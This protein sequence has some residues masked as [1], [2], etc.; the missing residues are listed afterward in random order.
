MSSLAFDFL[1]WGA[2]KFLAGVGG[3]LFSEVLI[4]AGFGSEVEI[5]NR[6]DRIDQGLIKVNESL[7]EVQSQLVEICRKLDMM[8]EAMKFLAR[9]AQLMVAWSDISAA[10]G[11]SIAPDQLAEPALLQVG[12]SQQSLL[13]LVRN[14]QDGLYKPTQAAQFKKDVEEYWKVKQ[15][16]QRMRTMMTDSSLTSESI[17]QIWTNQLLL[18]IN[19]GQVTPKDA[20]D[21]LEAWFTDGLNR[22]YTGALVISASLGAEVPDPRNAQQ[23]DAIL[24]REVT[25]WLLEFKEDFVTVYV[26]EFRRCVAFLLLNT[27]DATPWAPMSLSNENY[28]GAPNYAEMTMTEAEVFCNAVEKRFDLPDK[29]QLAQA[30]AGVYGWAIVRPSQVTDGKTPAFAPGKLPAREGRLIAQMDRFPPIKLQA[31]DLTA[32]RNQ[33]PQLG[34]RAAGKM[35]VSRYFWPWTQPL[36]PA[37]RPFDTNY[38]YEVITR[39]FTIL[40]PE[41]PILAAGLLNVNMLTAAAL[42]TGEAVGK[43]AGEWQ[44]TG[45][46]ARIVEPQQVQWG[47]TPYVL[48]DATSTGGYL[49]VGFNETHRR[50]P[51]GSDRV[52]VFKLNLFEYQGPAATLE[53]RTALKVNFLTKEERVGISRRVTASPVVKL[54]AQR[55]GSTDVVPILDTQHEEGGKY[56]L[57]GKSRQLFDIDYFK[58]EA[59]GT[60][61]KQVSLPLAQGDKWELVIE[62]R[63]H[64]DTTVVEPDP[65]SADD[66]CRLEFE[67]GQTQLHWPNAP[68][69]ASLAAEVVTQDMLAE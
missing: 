44:G 49:S 51:L 60:I 31:I 41:H 62:C 24:N 21:L 10:Y 22:L 46:L 18:K 19:A 53:L 45:A 8:T 23:R 3:K 5:K 25:E 16:M 29:A 47:R 32:A 33:F 66:H 61:R 17:L 11:V 20:Y 13:R 68:K 9:D 34:A 4:A 12:A 28:A 52:R 27:Y 38:R 35:L 37:R 14:S 26:R 48:Q 6:L 55:V 30:I 65:Q 1:E 59:A 2:G 40:G 50:H 39:N 54:Y 58:T 56:Y 43:H 67:L 57:V 36:P 7:L 15:A 42:G 64:N 63:F 69:Q